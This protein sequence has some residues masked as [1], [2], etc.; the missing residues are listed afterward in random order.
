MFNYNN[1]IQNILSAYL[2]DRKKLIIDVT[3]RQLIRLN[4]I[5]NNDIKKSISI[6]SKYGKTHF[7]TLDSL[8]GKK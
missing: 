4:R 3:G 8:I 5:R 2:E 6:K 1:V 7:I